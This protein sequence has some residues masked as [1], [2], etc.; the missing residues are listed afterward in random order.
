MKFLPSRRILCVDDDGDI[1]AL[2]AL[3]L[4]QLGGFQVT[5]C[6]SGREALELAPR[7]RPHLVLLDVMMPEM[8][9]FDTLRALRRLEG[10]RTTP[11]VFVTARG[12]DP[13]LAGIRDPAVLGVVTKPFDPLA[14]PDRLR[15]LL[16]DR[17]AGDG[18]G[19]RGAAPALS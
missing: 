11:V 16:D 3:V 2:L 8:D 12:D 13:A 1:R 17:G 19:A 15:R 9:G 14:L 6:G 4:T 5:A 10:L 18:T 7:V